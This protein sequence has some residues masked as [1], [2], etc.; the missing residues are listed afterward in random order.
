M[1]IRIYNTLT[2]K[3]EELKTLEP[4]KVRMYVC[5]P[6]VYSNAHV[7]HAMS[8]LVFDI[9]RRYL[10]Y[11]GYEVIHAM[12]F[13]DVDDK[14]I[15][16]ANQKGVNPFDLAQTYIDDYR[17]DLQHLNILAPTIQPRATREIEQIVRMVQNLID[18]GFAYPIDGD[19]YFR[20]L[21]DPEYGKLSGRHLEDMQAGSRID[22]DDRKEHP[23][24]FA[25]WKHAKPGEPAWD[26]PWGNGRP[27]W[28]I[29]C[30]AMNLHHL[31]EQID[32]HGGGNDLIFPHHENEIAQTESLTH[33]PFATFWVHNGML[34]LGGEKMSKSTGNLVTISEFLTKHSADSFRLLVL[35]GA[36]RGPL[37]FNDDA[38][39]QS[40]RSLERLASALRPALPGATGA[41][42]A[43]LDALKT[44]SASAQTGF[45]EAMDDD[46]NT[47][48]AL[49]AL[50]ELVRSINQTRADA[51]TSDELESAQK[52]LRRLTG[53][54]GLKLEE[55]KKDG[56]GAAPFIELL[57]EL[58]RDL[59][60]QKNYAMSDQIRK[61]LSD[62]GVTLEDS[63]D[64]TSWRNS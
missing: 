59:R 17:S 51:A 52:L 24:D 6:T 57:I 2:R 22:V 3:K 44:Q 31:G 64:G 20:V 16:R 15:N 35:T 37:A 28:H 53:V 8:A 43:S 14:I 39:A 49:A 40:E 36:Y 61:R 13:T 54:L 32:I 50:F 33:K 62:L 10:E 23:M 38:I 7:G 47:A 42:A 11:R 25:L 21:K 9:I 63:K 27:G 19:V 4:N 55:E 29:E 18:S 45:E 58:R 1:S 12:N 26:S 41:P 34:Q 30:S 5:G 60:A 56:Q 46:F 48:G